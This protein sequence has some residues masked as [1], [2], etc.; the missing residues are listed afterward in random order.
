MVAV[1]V[2]HFFAHALGVEMSKRGESNDADYLRFH[3]REYLIRALDNAL[4]RLRK[5]AQSL[6]ESVKMKMD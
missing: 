1:R 5:C 3:K 6:P 2:E 4:P